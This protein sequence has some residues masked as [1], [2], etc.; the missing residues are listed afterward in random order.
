MAVIAK[1]KPFI[2]A[3]Q[4]GADIHS[5]TASE[6]WEIPEEEVTSEQ[7]RAAKAI[8]FGIRILIGKTYSSILLQ[9]LQ[10]IFSLLKN[11]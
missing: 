2:K 7:R 9:K 6:V 1:D 3:L 11:G 4:D 8:N 10:N 5:R